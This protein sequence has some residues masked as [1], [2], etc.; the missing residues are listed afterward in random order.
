M[1]KIIDNFEQIKG[2]LF[3]FEVIG[4]INISIWIVGLVLLLLIP[5]FIT[6]LKRCNSFYFFRENFVLI[7][8]CLIPVA[9]IYVLLVL[10]PRLIKRALSLKNK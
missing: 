2:M 9:N 5:F 10:Y 8:L 6:F 1:N 7:F 3:N 4:N